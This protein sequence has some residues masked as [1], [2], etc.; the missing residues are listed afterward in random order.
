[1]LELNLSKVNV[2]SEVRIGMGKTLQ[3]AKLEV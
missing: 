2:F 1:M 3:E